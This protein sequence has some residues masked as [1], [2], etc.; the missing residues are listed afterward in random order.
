MVHCWSPKGPESEEEMLATAAVVWA[1]NQLPW[2]P[3]PL[4]LPR[5]SGKCL[6]STGLTQA[7][8]E[9]SSEPELP[10]W[11]RGPEH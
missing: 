6:S 9:H 5:N 1:P 11:G 2:L 10:P 3:T 8:S 4:L 7:S